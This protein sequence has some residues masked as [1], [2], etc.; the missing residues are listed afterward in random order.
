MNRINDNDAVE[1]SLVTKMEKIYQYPRVM[2]K[3][4]EENINSDNDISKIIDNIYDGASERQKKECLRRI[5][6][7]LHMINKNKY[8]H[9]IRT[10]V[11]I[12][13]KI[14]PK[15]KALNNHRLIKF[16]PLLLLKCISIIMQH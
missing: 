10:A 6:I 15:S 8:K 7:D 13:Y 9:A 16:F 3:V 4:I 1:K 2:K 14:Q 5:K 11:L 12:I